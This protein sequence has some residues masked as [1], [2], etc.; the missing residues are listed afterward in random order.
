MVTFLVQIPGITHFMCFL[1]PQTHKAMEDS[2][3]D[4]FT[5]EAK[6][7]WQQHDPIQ[8]EK[9]HTTHTPQHATQNVPGKRQR[10]V[11]ITMKLTD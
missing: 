6:L 2:N 1:P 7:F 11:P 3:S 4:F 10:T 8:L 5:M 9:L